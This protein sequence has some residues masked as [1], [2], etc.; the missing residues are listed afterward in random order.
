MTMAVSGTSTLK[1]SWVPPLNTQ[2]VPDWTNFPAPPLFVL[3]RED[4]SC[5][6]TCIPDSGGI[7]GSGQ[8]SDGWGW[9]PGFNT[10][11]RGQ[12]PL[13]SSDGIRRKVISP[14]PGLPAVVKLTPSG[15]VGAFRSATGSEAQGGLNIAERLFPITL[16]QPDPLHNPQL[17]DGSN[18]F[19]YNGYA[20][21]ELQLPAVV[22]AVGAAAADTGWLTSAN[23]VDVSIVGP[24]ISGQKPYI[25]SPSTGSIAA[26]TSGLDGANNPYPLGYFAFLG[27]PTMYN[28][29]TGDPNSFGNH[30]AI[31]KVD[32]QNSQT[33]YFQTFFRG[34]ASNWPGTDGI[35]PN[36]YHY[37]SQ[38][39][40]AS[41]LY[42]P[43][44]TNSWTEPGSANNYAIHIC[45][46]AYISG[47]ASG[48]RV[49]YLK[50]T[51]P[52]TLIQ[53]AGDLFIKGIHH[54][55][56]ENAHESGHRNLF[57]GTYGTAYTEGTYVGPDPQ[58]W[59]WPATS[60]G[61]NVLNS[62]ESSHHL[63][64]LSPD[65]TGA[66]GTQ[67]NG[68]VGDN[69]VIADI[70]ALA[71]IFND[72]N[73]WQKDWAAEPANAPNGGLQYGSYDY[74]TATPAGFHW[75]FYARMDSTSNGPPSNG[76]PAFVH[77]NTYQIRSLADLQAQYPGVPNVQSTG[78]LTSISQLGP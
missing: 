51:Q 72:V 74:K 20:V 34:T 6:I 16:S 46:S 11:L 62:W 43:N 35:T 49:F 38:V 52:T 5:F 61:D 42:D 23:H 26:Q 73:D 22:S 77:G 18:Q 57:L 28:G 7:S 53:Y 32:G 41:G 50:D 31:L 47:P 10:V 25:W 71:P 14:P 56:E 27:L 63:D 48:F 55:V 21:G 64:P 9:S 4:A 29:S 12:A 66:Y 68:D 58:D 1:Y 2:G 24:A 8:V 45:A 59:S 37:Y 60:E 39:E 15:Y 70:Q 44:S 75:S 76:Q 30:L 67:S 17:G 65:T 3:A 13:V 40:Q 69:E 36:W 54:F 19:V 78:I 33:A